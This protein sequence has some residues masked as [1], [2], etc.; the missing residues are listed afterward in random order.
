VTV[1]GTFPATA[2]AEIGPRMDRVVGSLRL[3]LDPNR[4]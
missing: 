2:A 1:V 4:S 3:G